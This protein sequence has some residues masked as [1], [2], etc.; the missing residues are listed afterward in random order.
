MR[1]V[2]LSGPRT[3]MAKADRSLML[4]WSSSLAYLVDSRQIKDSMSKNK[5]DGL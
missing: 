4:H 3:G 2:E 5:V 1:T